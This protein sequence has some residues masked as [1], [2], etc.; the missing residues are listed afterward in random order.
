MGNT[1]LKWAGG[2]H[3][4][5]NREWHRLPVNYNRYF[6]PFL[7][8]GSV[9]FHLHPQNAVLSDINQELINTYTAI[10][11]DVNNV[12]RN[13]KT[14]EKKHSKEYFYTVREKSQELMHL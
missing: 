10:R 11:D 8:G 3:W 13:L 5:V 4:F 12:Y 7:G 14:H 6:E 9:F 2:K 1:F